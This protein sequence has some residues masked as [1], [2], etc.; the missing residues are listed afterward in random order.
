MKYS[1]EDAR[2][3]LVD[4]LQPALDAAHGQ[5]RV[6]WPG[7]PKV[8]FSVDK[9]LF[10]NVDL[11]YDDGVPV[12]LGPQAPKRRIGN[13]VTEVNYKEGEPKDHILCNNIIDLLDSLLSDTDDMYPVRTYTAARVSPPNGVASGWTR[14]GLVTPFF[15]DTSR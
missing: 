15:F 4:R 2:Q 12:G 14:E 13:I 11:I 6:K 3:Q 5:V 7:C 1:F 10:I 8:D 9:S